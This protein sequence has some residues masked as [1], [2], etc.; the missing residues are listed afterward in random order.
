MSRPARAVAA[1]LLLSAPALA[2][3]APT[4]TWPR[5]RGPAGDAISAERDLLHA[6]PAAGPTVLWRVPL[7]EGYSGIVGA[8]DALYTMYGKGQDE[9]VARFDAASGKTVWS[10]RIDSKWV[11]RFGNGP[12]STPALDGDTLYALSARG[13]L[14]ALDT[15]DGS[16]RWSRDL[17]RD[18]GAEPPQWGVAT[19]PLVVD[20]LLLVNVGGGDGDQV[21]AFK[22]ASG[23]EVWRS[24]SG[25]AGYAA[26]LAITVGGVRQ[27][28]FFTARAL[29]AL[30]PAG[31]ALLWSVPWKTSYDVNAAAPVFVPPDRVFVSSGYDV[32][33]AL[34]RVVPG[35]HG[36]D[37]ERLWA[38]REMKNK[39][40]S[41]LFRDGL[42][43]GFDE[44]TFKCVDVASGEPRWEKRG[45]GHGSLIWADG[46]LVVL[47]DQGQLVLV[48]ATGE[49]YRELAR[50]QVF[51]GKS[52]TAPTLLGG[53]LLLR[54]EHELI[55]LQFSR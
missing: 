5:Y 23:E 43:Y 39:F 35:E 12:R 25:A 32:G 53:R 7:G 31:G 48:E 36:V 55:A 49:A 2:A 13:H 44:K 24:Q 41:S 1:A 45:L 37:V 11:D 50:A 10:R 22:K 20:E 18:F 30:D 28:L 52:W 46:M 6:F 3:D 15:A 16:L 34:L 26:P 9:F 33:G 38:S 17:G 21:V 8:G 14:A 51:K 47:G 27:V 19:C 4:P 29:I 54:D 42:L 40:S